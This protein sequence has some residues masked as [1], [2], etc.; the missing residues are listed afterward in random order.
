MLQIMMRIKVIVLPIFLTRF[1]SFHV[2]RAP[3]PAFDNRADAASAVLIG[4]CLDCV[5]FVLGQT[6]RELDSRQASLVD[7][8]YLQ[9]CPP[10]R[11]AARPMKKRPPEQ[12]YIR[13]LVGPR[14]LTLLPV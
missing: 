13:H 4:C 11:S 6:S 10:Q 14:R 1:S 7:N 3:F 8:A 9:C 2:R 5:V 12:E